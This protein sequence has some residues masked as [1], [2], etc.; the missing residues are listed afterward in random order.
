M[1]LVLRHFLATPSVPAL[2]CYAYAS[3][4]SDLAQVAVVSLAPV[5]DP[6]MEIYGLSPHGSIQG[7]SRGS[8]DLADTSG[9][10][11]LS[12]R[13]GSAFSGASASEPEYKSALA[14]LQSSVE[15]GWCHFQGVLVACD[16]APSKASVEEVSSVK[17]KLGSTE[18]KNGEFYSYG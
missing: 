6:S 7:S 15:G 3:A 13:S 5:Y 10:D 8:C 18:I 1:R 9:I 16:D 12:S 17:R 4:A 2:T 11:L 14:I